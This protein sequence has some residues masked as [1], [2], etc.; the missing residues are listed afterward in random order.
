MYV[1]NTHP[2]TLFPRNQSF[3]SQI[4]SYEK[5]GAVSGVGQW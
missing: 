2:C 3:Y 1:P 4:T 5:D